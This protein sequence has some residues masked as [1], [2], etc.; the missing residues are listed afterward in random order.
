MLSLQGCDTL[1]RGR[2]DFPT[3]CIL[4]TKDP[5]E[6]SVQGRRQGTCSLPYLY[7]IRL[8]ALRIRITVLLTCMFTW[9]FV[10]KCLI[11]MLLKDCL[12]AWFLVDVSPPGYTRGDIF[13][14]R[15]WNVFR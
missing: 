11:R 1:R 14:H 10:P 2:Y 9:L 7:V 6:R 15:D 12:L 13:V 4:L 5:K 8:P 3:K